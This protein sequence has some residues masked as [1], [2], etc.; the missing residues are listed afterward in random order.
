MYN[1]AAVA[2]LPK[3]TVRNQIPTTF[4]GRLEQVKMIEKS[5]KYHLGRTAAHPLNIDTGKYVAEMPTG[6]VDCMIGK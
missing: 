5:S 4:E 3:S 6:T 1:V 2:S